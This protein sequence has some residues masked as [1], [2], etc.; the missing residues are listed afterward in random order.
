MYLGL[1]IS[2]AVMLPRLRWF[3]GNRPTIEVDQSPQVDIQTMADGSIKSSVR[4]KILRT[5]PLS[6]E[7]LTD[8]EITTLKTIRDY[9]TEL[10]FQNNWEE[11]TWYYVII[12]DFKVSSVVYIGTTPLYSVSMT[13]RQTR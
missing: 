6:W 1:D 4:E 5:W 9:K 7:A 11:A 2:S 13:L 8:S 3:N 10:V 12:Q